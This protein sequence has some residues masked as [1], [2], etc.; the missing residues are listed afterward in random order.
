MT[1]VRI[2]GLSRIASQPPSGACSTD[3]KTPWPAPRRDAVGLRHKN[4]A[5]WP[6]REAATAVPRSAN[7]VV[8]ERELLAACTGRPRDERVHNS[9]K[10]ASHVVAIQVRF[11]HS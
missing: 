8:L 10:G 3:G 6:A 9:R 11:T 1:S 4:P 2:T 5:P 7:P